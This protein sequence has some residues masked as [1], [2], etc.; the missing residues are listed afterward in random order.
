MERPP[1]RTKPE[2]DT[3]GVPE[4]GPHAG[5]GVKGES[6]AEPQTEKDARGESET[7]PQPETDTNGV[8][9]AEPQPGA[10]QASA[11]SVAAGGES[12][13]GGAGG[14]EGNGTGDDPAA[15]TAP[16][17]GRRGRLVRRTVLALVL[18]LLVPVLAAETALRVNYLGDPADGTYTRGKDAIWLG[19]AWVD[20]RKTDADVKALAD[21]LGKTGIRDLY[22]HAGPLEHNGTLPASAYAGAPRFIAAVHREAP[23]LRVQAWLGD[24]L[25]SESPNGM[26]LERAE[27]RAA[28]VRST[29]EILAAGFQGAHFDLEPLHSGD[30]DYLGLLDDL[31]AVTKARNAQ[32][33][34]AAHQIDPVPGFHSFWGTTTGHPKWWSQKFFGQVARRVDQIAVMSYDTMQP[35]QSTYGGYVAQQTS[36]ALE[37]TPASTDLLMGLPFYHE[38]R[39]GH[40]NHAETVAAA[41]RGVRLGLSRTDA[42]RANFGVAAYVDFAATEQDWTSYEKDWVR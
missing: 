11:G 4:A 22:V 10:G 29:R 5:T 31:R 34:V 23:Q 15:G 40:W 12:A 21:R 13:V 1:G 38:N 7:D 24:V 27:T 26:R 20:G 9:Q 6:E 36:L 18:L 32:L 41:V 25:A 28:V 42:D 19:H 39:F 16:R 35:L 33:S 14:A 2:T 8:P 3:N 37:V 17:R 30:G